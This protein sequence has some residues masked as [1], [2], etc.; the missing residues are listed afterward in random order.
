MSTSTRATLSQS[1]ERAMSVLEV[2]DLHVTVE[3]DQGQYNDSCEIF[4]A[5]G[6]AF[7]IRANLWRES[8]GFDGDFFA[9]MEEIDLCWRL[10]LQ[11][12]K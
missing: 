4:W 5:S 1:K 7:F 2:K 12:K 3:T 11:G 9:H 10:Q 6:A 8:G